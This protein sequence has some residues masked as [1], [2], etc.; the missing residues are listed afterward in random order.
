MRAGA[1]HSG[2]QQAAVLVRSLVISH[3]LVSMR[4]VTMAVAHEGNADIVGDGVCEQ[5]VPVGCNCSV[6]PALTP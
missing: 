2:A 6:H 4:C 3:Y 1:A 5:A